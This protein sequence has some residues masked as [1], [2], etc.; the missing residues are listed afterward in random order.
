MPQ[1]NAPYVQYVAVVLH[2]PVNAQNALEV[3]NDL[4]EAVHP[5]LRKHDPE[6][7][8]SM[9]IVDSDNNAVV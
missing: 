6:R 3:F 1:Q 7:E 5:V 8:G 2:I 9:Y 4:A